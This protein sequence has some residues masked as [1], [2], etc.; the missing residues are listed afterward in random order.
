MGVKNKNNVLKQM[1]EILGDYN[2]LKEKFEPLRELGLLGKDQDEITKINGLIIRAM[3]LVL[4]H[5]GEESIYFKQMVLHS[6]SVHKGK[7]GRI[8][9]HA[10]MEDLRVLYDNLIKD[11][12]SL[13]QSFTTSLKF[14]KILEMN[15]SDSIYE[16]VIAE[17]NGTYIDHYFASMYIMVRKLLENLLYDCLKAYYGT[18]DVEKYY[19]TRK[20]RH[21]GYEAL[22]NNFNNMI[23]DQNFKI[24]VGDIDQKFIDLLKEFQETGNRNAHSLFNLIH[25]DFIEEC[26]E[27][28]NHLIK[29]LDWILQKL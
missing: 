21:Q 13:E 4:K 1:K 20:N 10:V 29:K 18:Q 14:E 9:L 3:A 23:H 28:I 11:Y 27:K 12:E 16:E 5:F 17:I 6:Q 22:I 8:E 15:L 2:K 19:N 24:M 26:K 25:Q 7:C